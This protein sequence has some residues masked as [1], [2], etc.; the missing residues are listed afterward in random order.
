MK[1]GQYG[2]KHTHIREYVNILREHAHPFRIKFN[3]LKLHVSLIK[4]ECRRRHRR[5]RAHFHRS[6]FTLFIVIVIVGDGDVVIFF[7]PQ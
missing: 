6:L 2:Q 5:R 4:I 1:K 3:A 7:S